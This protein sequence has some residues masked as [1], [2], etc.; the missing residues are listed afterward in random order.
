MRVIHVVPSVDEEA[1]G[2]SYSV[3]R[4][5]ESLIGNGADAEVA[6]LGS[7]ERCGASPYVGTF[8]AGMGPRRLGLSPRMH[9][10]LEEKAASGMCDVMHNHGLWMMPG[11]YAGRV[12]KQHRHCRLVM[13]PRGMLSSWA[14]GYHALRKRVFWHLLQQPTMR[15]AAC[16]HAT[17]EGEYADIRRLGFAQPICLL[18]N[19]IDVPALHRPPAAGRRRL[20]FLGRIHPK[21]GVDVLLQ[22]WSAVQTRFHD[23]ELHVVGSDE[24]GYLAQMRALAARLKLE[25]VVF[26]GPLYGRH[27]WRA[28]REAALFVLPTHSENFGNTVAEAM[29]A[30]TPVIVTIGAPWSGLPHHGAGWWIEIGVGALIGCLEDALAR[31]PETLSAMGLAGREWMMRDYTWHRV[32]EQC[33]ATYRWLLEDGAPP[34][35]VRLN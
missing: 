23:W 17:G 9:R 7:S 31:S 12:C 15:D 5:C 19:G 11:V 24:G 21:K 20:L 4:L 27:K 28:Y 6:A 1:S 32:G 13:S 18:P 30:G 3:V 8:P 22:A 25:R 10:W 34:S 2:P 35:C 33:A 16:F 14:L 26:Q 29:A